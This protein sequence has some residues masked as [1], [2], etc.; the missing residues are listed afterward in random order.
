MP[1]FKHKTNK[2]IFVDKKRIMTLDSVHR[3]LQCEFNLIN[4]EVLPRLI[5]RKNEIMN[6]L[7]DVNVILDV[8]EKIELQD[9]LYDIKRRNL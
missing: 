3:E 5:R 6:Q 2:K 7:N 9:S 8:N 4:T 1:S